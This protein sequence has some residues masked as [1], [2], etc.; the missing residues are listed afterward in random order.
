MNRNKS[1]IK[2]STTYWIK[3]KKKKTLK[4]DTYLKEIQM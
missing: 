4:W 3:Q 1:K 2:K